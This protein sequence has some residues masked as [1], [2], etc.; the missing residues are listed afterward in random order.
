MKSLLCKWCG[1][2]I[3]NFTDNKIVRYCCGD[4]MLNLDNETVI[5]DE[6]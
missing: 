6:M 4:E 3:L 2:I 1:C 5:T